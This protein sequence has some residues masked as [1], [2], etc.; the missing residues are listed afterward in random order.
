MDA[1][2]IIPVL[3]VHAGRVAGPAAPAFEG[4]PAAWACRLEL[5]GA[6][7]ILF[8]ADSA[9][10]LDWMREVAGSLSVPFALEAPF[11]SWAELEEALEAGADKVV[12]AAPAAMLSAAAQTFG[13][14]RVAVVVDAVPAQ[15]GWR[16]D[17]D[18]EGRDA[19]AWMLELEQRGAGE[20][21]LRTTP[22]GE[23]GAALFQGAARMALAVL[24]QSAGN[25]TLAAEAL[26]RGADGVTFPAGAWT[27]RQWKAALGAHGLSVRDPQ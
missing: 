1:K 18:P 3:Q 19:L 2:R 27:A 22:E 21:L 7:G 26:L 17:L 16:V 9:S 6:D 25:A 20:I 5:E 13:R 12:L 24:C 23:A 8:Q 10:G 11:R 15:S 14:A 4:R